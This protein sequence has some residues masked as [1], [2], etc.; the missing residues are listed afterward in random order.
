MAK[1]FYPRKGH[2]EM[3]A[4]YKATFRSLLPEIRH[5][6]QDARREG[7]AT[8]VLT[9]NIATIVVWRLMDR[10][11]KRLD[12]IRKLRRAVNSLA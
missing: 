2:R 6:V 7:Q 4:G 8:S 3:S 1:I 10:D 9:H 5:L 11:K 12:T